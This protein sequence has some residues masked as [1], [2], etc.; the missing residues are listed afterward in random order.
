[1]VMRSSP[2]LARE[3]SELGD[4]SAK[5]RFLKEIEKIRVQGGYY[6]EPSPVPDM[7]GA[8]NILDS[9]MNVASLGLGMDYLL[10]GVRLLK[11][12]TYFQIHFA[13]E[14]VLIN[15]RDPLFGMIKSGGEVYSTGLSLS[16]QL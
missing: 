11:V 9:D 15:D 6:Y 8:M 13:R 12:Q 5:A 10:K 4:L 14:R 1:M 3:A 16:I 2:P 7:N